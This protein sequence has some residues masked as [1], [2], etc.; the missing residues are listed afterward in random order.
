M[1][2]G[3]SWSETAEQV[4]RAWMAFGA[5]G[6][7]FGESLDNRQAGTAENRGILNKRADVGGELSTLTI[8]QY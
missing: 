4:S 5:P 6:Y 8:S 2:S 1:L 7:D 3:F